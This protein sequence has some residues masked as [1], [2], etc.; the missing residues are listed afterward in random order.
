VPDEVYGRTRQHFSEVELATLTL[1]V[2]AIN[3]WNRIA[4]AFRA[5]PGTYERPKP[6]VS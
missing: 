6:A 5:V 3:G 2:V 4:I 1:A